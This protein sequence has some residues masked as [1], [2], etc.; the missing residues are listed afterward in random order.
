MTGMRSNRTLSGAGATWR[1]L[2]WKQGNTTDGGRDKRAHIA[3]RSVGCC[4]WEFWRFLHLSPFCGNV[5]RMP[6]PLYLKDLLHIAE[7]RDGR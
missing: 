5:R 1:A 2:R 7:R 3:L 6:K 4:C